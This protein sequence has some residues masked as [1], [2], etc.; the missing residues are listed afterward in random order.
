MACR[1]MIVVQRQAKVFVFLI[2]DVDH[3]RSSKPPLAPKQ[4]DSCSILRRGAAHVLT[5]TAAQ[6]ATEKFQADALVGGCELAGSEDGAAHNIPIC[7]DEGI[8]QRAGQRWNGR[9]DRRHRV[10]SQ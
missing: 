3:S 5:L 1:E 6:A 8:Y 10:R 7:P 2:V 4:G 9:S